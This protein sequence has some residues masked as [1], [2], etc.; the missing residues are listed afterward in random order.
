MKYVIC[1]P[2][3][4]KKIDKEIDKLIMDRQRGSLGNLRLISFTVSVS[5]S[6]FN[7]E[8]AVPST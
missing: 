3:S 7:I 4:S 5:F 1:Y 8:N 6:N 2:F